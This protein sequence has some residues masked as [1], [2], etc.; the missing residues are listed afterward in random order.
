MPALPVNDIIEWDILNWSQLIKY[1]TPVLDSLP[2]NSKVLAIG[3]RNGGL[4]AWL[5]LMGFDVVCTDREYPTEKAKQL[6]SRL[7]IGHKITY[8]K[9]DIVNCDWEPGTFDVIVAK[10]VIGGLKADPRDRLTRNFQVQQSAVDNIHNLLKDKGYFFSAENMQGSWFL[11]QLKKLKNKDRGW[12]YLNWDEL[13][14]LYKKF[15]S[16][17]VDAFGV[18]PTAFASGAVNKICFLINKCLFGILPRGYKYISFIIT[19]R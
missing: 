3:E 15:E 19:Q 6:H 7:G 16:T 9:L 10:S 17:K 12:R 11:K 5:A 13:Q 2:R 8:E 4:A 18:L 14:S 1:W